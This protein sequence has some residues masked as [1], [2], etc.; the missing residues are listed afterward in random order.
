MNTHFASSLLSN[1]F[2]N[3]T[4][5]SNAATRAPYRNGLAA[6]SISTV[7]LQS[8]TRAGI[9]ILTAEGD[10]VTLSTTTTVHARSVVYNAQGLV[11]G[12]AIRVHDSATEAQVTRQGVLT[13]EGDLDEHE[14]RA[15]EQVVKQVDTLSRRAASGSLT[16]RQIPSS[17]LIAEG[18]LA[19]VAVQVQVAESAALTT[20]SQIRG[21]PRDIDA[22]DR[23]DRSPQHPTR[24]L[25][26]APGRE[27]EK[28]TDSARGIGAF[29]ER[30]GER[31]GKRLEQIRQLLQKFATTVDRQDE[32]LA[33]ANRVNDHGHVQGHDEDKNTAGGHG[34]ALREH[35]KNSEKSVENMLSTLPATFDTFGAV[36]DRVAGDQTKRN[37]SDVAAD[38]SPAD[39]S[40]PRPANPTSQAHNVTS[41]QI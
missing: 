19:A 1:V 21:R 31:I 18:P 38:T 28:S 14:L 27:D 25:E 32:E 26:G 5:F 6:H 8:Q 30:F 34:K 23:Q 4:H 41:T 24:S 10:T 16:S 12:Q 33:R 36:F 13:V 15:I 37:A 20:A 7:D 35:R 39:G 29:F 40:A 2:T 3:F 9:A 17:Q 11:D 22:H